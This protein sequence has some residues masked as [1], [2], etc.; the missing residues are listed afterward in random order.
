MNFEKENLKWISLPFFMLAAVAFILTALI[1][2]MASFKIA[3]PSIDHAIFPFERLRPLHTL[4]PIVGVLA[5]AH[6][7]VSYKTIKPAEK[8]SILLSNS[9]FLLLLFF[10]CGSSLSLAMGEFSGREYFSWPPLFSIPLILSV[11]IMAYY[12]LRNLRSLLKDLLKDHG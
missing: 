2:L 9:S 12:F 11:G 7:W 3:F 4:F 6:G 8:N 1:G 5:G 10:I